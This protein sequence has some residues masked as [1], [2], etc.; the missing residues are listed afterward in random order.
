M[1]I[2]DDVEME[3]RCEHELQFENRNSQHLHKCVINPLQRLI[4]IDYLYPSSFLAFILCCSVVSLGFILPADAQNIIDNS[5]KKITYTHYK[6]PVN[7]ILMH[8][9]I[10]GKGDPIVLLHGWP[11]TWYE[12][13]NVIPELI[14]NN[15]TI[16]APDMRGLGDSEK[17]Q[18]GYDTKNL[19]EDIYQL[20][21]KLGYSK[22][23]FVAHDWGGPVAYSYAAEHPEDVG[24]MIILDTLLP[25]FGLEEA[26]DFSPNGIWHFSFHAVRDLPEKLIEGKEDLYL[27]WFYDWTYNQSAITPQDREV[28]IQQYSQPGAMRA[29]FEYYRAIFEDAEQNKEYGKEKLQIPILTIGGEAAIGNSTTTSFQKVATNVTGIT[30]PNTGH[31]IPEERPNLLIKQILDFF[32]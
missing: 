24:K 26:G 9:V 4:L 6:T 11:Q 7:G 31:F 23:N 27:N 16:I 15:Y 30:L 17:T 22:I 14:A 19:A 29:G 13:R 21:E 32:K 8:Y 20:V 2:S 5:E 1:A 28:Y 3:N 10:G 12:W 25:G 18:T